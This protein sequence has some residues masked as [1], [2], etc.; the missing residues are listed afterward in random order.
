[1]SRSGN[2]A[3]QA[4]L[5]AERE[6]ERSSGRSARPRRK[7]SAVPGAHR[8]GWLPWLGVSAALNAGSTLALGGLVSDD[9]TFTG[10]LLGMIAMLV[11]G[12]T[13]ILGS[14]RALLAGSTFTESLRWVF[15]DRTL[16]RLASTTLVGVGLILLVQM[17]GYGTDSRTFWWTYA[18][19]VLVVAVSR[20]LSYLYTAQ[21]A[22]FIDPDATD[23]SKRDRSFK[24][25]I[26]Y[27]LSRKPHL[28]IAPMIQ[29]IIVA[30]VPQALMLTLLNPTGIDY[31]VA[32]ALSGALVPAFAAAW[33][34]WH[35]WGGIGRITRI[36]AGRPMRPIRGPL[37][38]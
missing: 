18:F 32:S 17:T 5:D 34:Q 29:A 8:W 22:E 11:F 15:R 7:P 21:Y 35:V 28:L 26:R 23:K 14:A 19:L 24:G 1:M 31:R 37:S 2:P 13:V 33:A 20:G 25:R 10:F 30:V 12:Y 9:V 27:R 6:A 36:T 3:R 16:T 4:L 38:A